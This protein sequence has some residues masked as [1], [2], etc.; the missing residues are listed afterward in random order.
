MDIKRRQE[1]FLDA[2]ETSLVMAKVSYARLY[3]GLV[4]KSN[5]TETNSLVDYPKVI[6]LDAWTFVDT[7]NRL[8]ILVSQMPGLKKNSRVTQFQKATESTEILRDFVQHVNAEIPKVENT[9]WPIW[10]SISWVYLSFDLDGK[11]KIL[12]QSI[13]PGRLAKVKGIPMVNPVGKSLEIPID[14]ISLSATGVTL[15]LSDIHRLVVE[16]EKRFLVALGGED[17][18]D[19]G[20][21]GEAGIKR[22]TLKD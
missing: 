13:I 12:I 21:I 6:L 15:N 2:I 20:R 9:G 11:P 10:G 8:R 14:H 7:I 5:P 4:Q 3:Q 1:L 22:I 19:T 17:K 16:F 18:I